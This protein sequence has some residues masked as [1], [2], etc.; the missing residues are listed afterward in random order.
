MRKEV[1]T[2][3]V[4]NCGCGLAS[5]RGRYNDFAFGLKRHR[6]LKGHRCGGCRLGTGAMEDGLHILWRSSSRSG[7]VFIEHMT[8]IYTHTRNHF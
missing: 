2:V 7:R 3:G 4:G 5:I 8:P 1:E 6:Q